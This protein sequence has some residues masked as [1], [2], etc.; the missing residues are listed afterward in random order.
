M[1]SPQHVGT[2]N[3]LCANACVI[4]LEK[5]KWALEYIAH[6]YYAN[7]EQPAWIHFDFLHKLLSRLDN[8]DF[9]LLAP[10]SMCARH[11]IPRVCV[12]MC[13]PSGPGKDLHPF[14]AHAEFPPCLCRQPVFWDLH[15][16]GIFMQ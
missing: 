12:Q 13:Q 14:L 15:D 7:L 2:C 16:C 1:L 9:E 3:V 5:C 6:G 4:A 10:H 8:S 11:R